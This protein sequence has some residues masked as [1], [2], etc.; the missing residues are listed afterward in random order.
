[1]ARC[2]VGCSIK[3][4]RGRFDSKTAINARSLRGA[5][6]IVDGK[7]LKYVC[8]RSGWIAGFPDRAAGTVWTVQVLADPAQKR[9]D[10]LRVTTAVF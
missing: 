5:T 6:E 9:L 2:F 8:V 4:S 10:V 1:M 7:R 3:A